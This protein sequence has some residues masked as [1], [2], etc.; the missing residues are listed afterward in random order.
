VQIHPIIVCRIGGILLK[1]RDVI[2]IIEVNGWYPGTTKGCH[3]QYN[4]P[5]KQGRFT[6]AGHPEFDRALVFTRTP[7]PTKP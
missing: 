4:I 6:M 1:V 3:R 2:K 5:I 7:D